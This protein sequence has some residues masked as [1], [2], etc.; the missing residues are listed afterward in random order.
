MPPEVGAAR[1]LLSLGCCSAF[2]VVVVVKRPG[3]MA[4]DQKHE[5]SCA[6][7]SL[8][9]SQP[10][11]GVLCSI[12]FTQTS[13]TAVGAEHADGDKIRPPS[14]VMASFNCPS[15]NTSSQAERGLK[16]L[17]GLS[18]PGGAIPFGCNKTTWL[19]RLLLTSL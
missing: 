18:Q 8:P 1:H 10:R 16:E 6:W 13:L 12:Y 11:S 15:E 19:G 4:L 17:L 14:G 7:S 9:R 3:H 2:S 5:P